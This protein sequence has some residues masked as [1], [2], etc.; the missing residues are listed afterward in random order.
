MQYQIYLTVA[1][2]SRFWFQF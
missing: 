2:R 1:S